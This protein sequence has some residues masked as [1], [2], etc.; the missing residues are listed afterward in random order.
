M[1]GDEAERNRMQCRQGEETERKLTPVI[2]DA[3]SNFVGDGGIQCTES[4]TQ[5][6]N[7][8]VVLPLDHL[9]GNVVFVALFVIESVRSLS[10]RGRCQWCVFLLCVE[11]S[12]RLC[13]SDREF[14]SDVQV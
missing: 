11:G 9:G 10:C 8:L 4:S 12:E 13:K 3:L 6:V 14:G 1:K 7:I 2:Q 5:D